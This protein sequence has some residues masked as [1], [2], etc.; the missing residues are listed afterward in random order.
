MTAV[1]EKTAEQ[2][3]EERKKKNDLRKNRAQKIKEMMAEN[4][5]AIGKKQMKRNMLEAKQIAQEMDTELVEQIDENELVAII[6]K[7]KAL[8]AKHRETE[9]L[10]KKQRDEEFLSNATEEEAAKY[11][12]AR[13]VTDST[14]KAAALAGLSDEELDAIYQGYLKDERKKAAK[15]RRALKRNGLKSDAKK[16]SERKKKEDEQFL[17]TATKEQAERYIK[18]RKFAFGKEK[19]DNLMKMSNEEFELQY[20]SYL[21]KERERGAKKRQ[22]ERERKQAEKNKERTM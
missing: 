5:K 17:A 6:K 3:A 20:Q 18:A 4:E 14:A 11:I 7:R 1:K 10:R 19:I 15:R 12:K 8:D 22:A 16:Y 13:R 9:D 21:K 2:I